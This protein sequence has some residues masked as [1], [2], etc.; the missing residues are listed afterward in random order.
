MT[1]KFIFIIPWFGTL[2]PWFDLFLFSVE[3]NPIMDILLYT[4][5]TNIRKIQNLIV[6][7]TT[8]DDYCKKISGALDIE[9]HPNSAYKLCDVKPFYGYIHQDEIQKYDF[10]GFCDID[11]ILGNVKQFITSRL[12]RD[13]DFISCH[14]DRVSGHFFLMRNTDSIRKIGF[15][16]IDWKRL[17]EDAKIFVVDEAYLTDVLVP[18]FRKIQY[19]F[20]PI[21]AMPFFNRRT[22]LQLYKSIFAQAAQIFWGFRRRRLYFKEMFTTPVSDKGYSMQYLYD[23]EKLIDTDNNQEMIYLHFLFFK[24]RTDN[25]GLWDEKTIYLKDINGES[26][27]ENNV[28]IDKTGFHTVHKGK[29]N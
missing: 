28:L 21:A 27:N 11:L 18:H 2:P 8:F 16:I 14:A 4:N 24:Q 13:Y 12:L 20:D 1:A 22:A 9:F 25:R 19:L 10:F 7:H 3:Q 6:K 23:R 15:N 17:L 26:F 5:C 29:I